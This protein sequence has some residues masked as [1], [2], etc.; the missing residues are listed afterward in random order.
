[1]FGTFDVETFYHKD[2]SA[3]C[4][5][6]VEVKDGGDKH[7]QLL[8]A[9]CN[10]NRPPYAIISSSNQIRVWFNSDRTVSK[11]GFNA[12]FTS[13]EDKA[14]GGVLKGPRGVMKSPRYM[15]SPY[16][17]DANCE[18]VI[19]VEVGKFIRLSFV[20][21]GLEVQCARC[22]CP[23]TL[24][25]WDGAPNNETLI[26]SYCQMIEPAFQSK[27][28]RLRLKF[29]SDREGR[30]R[31]FKAEYATS[32]TPGCGWDIEDSPKTA[33]TSPY[34]PSFYPAATE[35][36]W[37]VRAPPNQYVS[38]RFVE[39]VGVNGSTPAC[40]MDHIEIH[41][42]HKTTS[43]SLGRFCNFKAPEVIVSSG[44]EMTVRFQS[45]LSVSNGKFTALFLTHSR[46]CNASLGLADGRIS[47]TQL[48]AS[49]YF[50]RRI[51]INQFFYHLPRFARLDGE[52]AWCS[53]NQGSQMFGAREYLQID[54]LNLTKIS[55]VSTQGYWDYVSNREHLD[56]ITSYKVE[57]SFDRLYWISYSNGSK[58]SIERGYSE[59]KGNFDAQSIVKRALNPPII[60]KLIRIIPTSY[61]STM[62]HICLRAEVHGCPY[63]I[64]CG[65]TISMKKPG[66][67]VLRG[68]LRRET[69]CTWVSIPSPPSIRGLVL[70]LD[71]TK[72]FDVPCSMGY[73]QIEEEITGK[74]TRMCD[75]NSEATYIMRASHQLVMKVKLKEGTDNIGFDMMYST[76]SFGCGDI[77]YVSED[78]TLESPR[79]PSEYG[80]DHMCTWVLSAKPEAKITIEFEEFSLQPPNNGSK[81]IDFLEIRDGQLASSALLDTYC[82]TNT[83]AKFTSTANY[84]RLTFMSDRDVTAK[85]FKLLYTYIPPIDEQPK[86]DEG[87]GERGKSSTKSSASRRDLLYVLLWLLALVSHC[88]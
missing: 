7:K 64:D 51:G 27:S 76:E 38:I 36:I 56:F 74:S 86:D 43:P 42:G 33:I 26:G 81:C 61:N 69:E 1:M 79:Y 15:V 2:G 73:V 9:Y 16:P 57:Y 46:E 52:Y 11:K 28:N 24:A 48:S 3:T 82:G 80:T 41:D 40:P 37:R 22:L 68:H 47:D 10:S 55:A 87:E 63:N 88:A 18:W 34:Y 20:D 72:M 71:F 83:P 58:D 84:I 13:H 31:G 17:N 21:F 5:D 67:V 53:Q 62:Y 12:T 70:L 44:N 54:L 32:L 35:C 85:G 39:F 4:I 45:S 65:G 75:Q 30:H 50:A 66:K 23:D 6:L 49:S 8:G 25:I 60:A 19:E 29:V 14:C 77:I 78:G 59:F